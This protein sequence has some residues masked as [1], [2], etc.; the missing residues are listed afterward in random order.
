MIRVT[1]LY[2]FANLFNIWLSRRQLGSYICC[3]IQ[4]VRYVIEVYENAIS[5]KYVVGKE[6]MSQAPCEGFRTPG[7]LGTH[8]GDHWAT[9]R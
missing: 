7:V 1:L 5:H 8:L 9:A 4:L 3:R 2:I 6:N